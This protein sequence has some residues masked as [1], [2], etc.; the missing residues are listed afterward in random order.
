MHA[1]P[2]VRCWLLSLLAAC[3]GRCCGPSEEVDE[4]RYEGI[5]TVTFDPDAATVAQCAAEC[6]RQIPYRG[7]FVN[8]APLELIECGPVSACSIRQLP[9][10]WI[11]TGVETGSDEGRPPPAPG[12]YWAQIECAAAATLHC[13]Y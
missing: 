13:P 9:D 7:T 2:L 6:C 8:V 11:D 5:V 1:S 12:N 10:D 3:E 4:V